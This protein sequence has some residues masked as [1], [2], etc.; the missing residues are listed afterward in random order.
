MKEIVEI[1][2]ENFQYIY[3]GFITIAI[4]QYIRGIKVK[5]TNLFFLKI[6]C[7]SYV[8]VSIVKSIFE[9]IVPTEIIASPRILLRYN[10][11]LVMLSLICPFIIYRINRS[12]LLK[13]FFR[14]NKIPIEI[15]KNAFDLIES[16]CPE[17]SVVHITVYMNNMIYSGILKNAETEK[18]GFVSIKH[19]NKYIIEANNN[20]KKISS[21]RISDYEIIIPLSNISYYYY[22]YVDSRARLE[23]MVI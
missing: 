3:P 1:I 9:I 7:I 2:L 19:W 23:D 15:S 8:M 13:K 20:I 16:K 5:D 14:W 10:I 18:E 12:D 11:I 4:Y 6:V 22:K 17:G 21:K